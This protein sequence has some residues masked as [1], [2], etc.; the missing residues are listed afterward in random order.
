MSSRSLSQEDSLEKEMAIHSGVLAW[1]IPW[2]EAPVRLQSMGWQRVGQ[3]L[4]TKSQQ[5]QQN[6]KIKFEQKVSF[7]CCFICPR[8]E[9]DA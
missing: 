5:Q 9:K 6:S 8:S 3:D 4:A 2:T 1:K 7:L